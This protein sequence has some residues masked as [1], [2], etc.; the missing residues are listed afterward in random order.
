MTLIDEL[1]N[2]KAENKALREI[3]EGIFA[4][5]EV[6]DV[7]A[8]RLCGVPVI[9]MEHLKLKKAKEIEVKARALMKEWGW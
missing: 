6:S 8:C 7:R 5:P 9:H 1:I 3:V 2:L 4:I